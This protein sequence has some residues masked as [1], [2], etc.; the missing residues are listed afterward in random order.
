V[1]DT[2]QAGGSL[3]YDMTRF[4]EEG[5]NTELQRLPQPT[6]VDFNEDGELVISGTGEI[7]TTE[8][9]GTATEGNK[10]EP[11]PDGP[12]GKQWDK[13]YKEKFDPITGLELDKTEKEPIYPEGYWEEVKKDLE[14][15]LPF[16][17]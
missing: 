17:L 5:V 2:I 7:V 9:T 6:Y 1:I 4:Y 12:R 11:R 10:V 8:T 14:S 3:P 13:K 15:K 16:G